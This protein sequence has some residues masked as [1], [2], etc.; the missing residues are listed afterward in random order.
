[1]NILP[2]CSKRKFNKDNYKREQNKNIRHSGVGLESIQA[3]TSSCSLF[4]LFV[5]GNLEMLKVKAYL[6]ICIF[7]ELVGF[8][9]Q[10]RSDT[11]PTILFV[12][13]SLYKG[14]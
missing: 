6:F 8:L 9:A 13:R 3:D 4:T 14:C 2:G 5:L 10:L 11:K 7:G 1:M 12:S